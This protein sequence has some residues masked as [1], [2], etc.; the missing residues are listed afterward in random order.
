MPVIATIPTTHIRA[1]KAA[2]L[3]PK[4]ESF[5]EASVFLVVAVPIRMKNIS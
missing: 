4:N 2:L 1:M 3:S 5:F